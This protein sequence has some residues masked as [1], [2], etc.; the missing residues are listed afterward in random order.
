MRWIRV[1]AR[2]IALLPEVSSDSLMSFA[3]EIERHAQRPG[4]G[5]VPFADKLCENRPG[6]IF[7]LLHA[8]AKG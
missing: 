3:P 2:G 8:T 4:E 6:E 7:A 1:H 5:C